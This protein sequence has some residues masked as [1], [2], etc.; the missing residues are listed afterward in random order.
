MSVKKIARRLINSVKVPFQYYAALKTLH[1]CKLEKKERSCIRVVFVMQYVPSWD[2]VKLLYE[3]MLADPE[4]E[5]YLVCVPME[6]NHEDISLS[7][8]ERNDTYE[9]FASRGY[10]CVNALKEGGKWL[11]LRELAPDY[12]IYTRPYNILLPK[13]YKSSTVAKFSHICVVLYG[14]SLSSIGYDVIN[15]DFF[16]YV[17]CYFAEDQ[18]IK[19]IFDCK[20][21]IGVKYGLQK[22][23]VKGVPSLEFM[24]RERHEK[25]DTWN[26]GKK[27][28]HVLWLPRWSTDKR[29]GGSNFF[30]YKDVLLTY[31]KENQNKL[32]IRPHP[33]MLNNFIKTGEWS[34]E[35]HDEFVDS[36]RQSENIMLDTTKS[37]MATLWGTDILIADITSMIAEFFLTGKPIIYCYPNAEITY[38]K[39]MQKILSCSYIVHDKKELLE[40]L[41]QLEEGIDPLRKQRETLAEEMIL[42]YAEG[43]TERIVGAIKSWVS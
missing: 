18:E 38:T 26:F 27:G 21:F 15:R 41:H 32:L 39:L 16:N 28:L 14:M 35:Q 29:I 22:A 43:C 8:F 36:C 31:Y 34:K 23:V 24:L 7:K 37:Y 2:K 25:A 19:G 3:A 11:D 42:D 17:S 12:V 6:Q 9:Y 20:F 5:P 30:Q 10:Q 40:I 1:K 33:L 4:M 13:E